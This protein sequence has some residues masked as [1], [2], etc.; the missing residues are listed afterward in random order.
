M[1]YSFDLDNTLCTQKADYA[2]AE[3]F[4]DR[5]TYVNKLYDK[6][7]KIYIETARGQVTGNRREWR[8]ITIRQLKR[9]GVKYH[10]LQVGKKLDADFFIDDKSINAKDFFI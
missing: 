8:N 9:W 2:M 6:G 7:H 1:I 4:K 10:K 5:I 3:P